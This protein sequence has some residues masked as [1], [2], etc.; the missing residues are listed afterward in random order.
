V[1][2][3][4]KRVLD[5][6]TKEIRGSGSIR[7]EEYAEDHF[8]SAP[9]GQVEALRKVSPIGGGGGGGGVGVGE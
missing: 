4:L 2:S 8:E 6:N 5:G 3:Q 7:D 1:L 9:H